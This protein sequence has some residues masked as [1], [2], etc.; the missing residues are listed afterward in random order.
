MKAKSILLDKYNIVPSPF[1][2]EL[3]QHPLGPKLQN[4]L[5]ENTKRR[6]VPN[7]LISGRTIGG[8]DEIS[9]LHEEGELVEKIRSLGGKQMMEVSLKGE[10]N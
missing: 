7:I 5:A 6:T 2:V 3:D 10:E 1:V 8:G 4:L 9:T